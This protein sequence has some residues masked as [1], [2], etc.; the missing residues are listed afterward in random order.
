MRVPLLRAAPVL[1]LPVND[2]K[3]TPPLLQVAEAEKHIAMATYLHEA[4]N[5]TAY[6]VLLV[7]SRRG[8]TTAASWRRLLF[9]VQQASSAI[10]APV[11]KGITNNREPAR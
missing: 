10:Y 7:S 3:Q 5:A 6:G 4:L 9:K 11:P 1:T 8:G 2:K